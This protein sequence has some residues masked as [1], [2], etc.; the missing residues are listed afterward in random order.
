MR[1][2]IAGMVLVGCLIVG[3]CGSGKKGATVLSG[4][5]APTPTS[6][7]VTT[8]SPTTGPA[9]TVA[10]STATTTSPPTTTALTTTTAA[11]TTTTTIAIP[12]AMPDLVG[13]QL[14]DAKA[15]LTRYNVRI[16]ERQQIAA[17][18]E[19]TIISQDPT[20]GA[21]FSQT[22]TL[23][24]SVK[25]PTVPEVVGLTFGDAKS[26]LELQGFKVTESA[27]I[28][29]TKADGLVLSQNPPA[30]T[31][32][33]AEVALSVAHRP[34]VVF[35]SQLQAVAADAANTSG[36]AIKGNAKTYNRSV[37]FSTYS[38]SASISFDLSR[39]FR[40]LTGDLVFDD[41]SAAT[42]QAKLEL[43]GDGRLLGEYEIELG[44]M[45][46]VSVDVTGVLR[47]VLVVTQLNGR[48]DGH[49]Y[50]ADPKLLGIQDEVPTTTVKK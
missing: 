32:N 50:L 7:N 24:F 5:T 34:V 16:S 47:L 9:T 46:P 10:L 12:K 48:T 17:Q 15:Q 18:P 43:F 20:A 23:T 31:A 36:E 19:G 29:E 14:T 37:R 11:P 21:P 1:M 35:L 45:V 22:V 8:V 30:G 25:P 44:K 28:N 39:G 27:V 6:A 13:Q 41:R 26:R 38:P 3:A 4:S 42:L 40:L 49:V 33:A 2:N